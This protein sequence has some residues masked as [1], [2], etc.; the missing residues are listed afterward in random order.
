VPATV[1]IKM[2]RYHYDY[3]GEYYSDYT[4]GTIHLVSKR[5]RDF[6]RRFIDGD[7]LVEIKHIT[8]PEWSSRL[9]M[10]GTCLA[11]GKE[12]M[13]GNDEYQ[14]RHSA[15]LSSS[16]KDCRVVEC[17]DKVYNHGNEV[18]VVLLE[19]MI[20]KDHGDNRI[21]SYVLLGNQKV[22]R[23]SGVWKSIG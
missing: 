22:W 12:I 16:P 18:G 17:K 13:L 14:I 21:Y 15:W 2:S 4:A 7:E 23:F 9:T 6:G 19:A 11:T 1:G 8:S 10:T 5:I 20:T 3:E